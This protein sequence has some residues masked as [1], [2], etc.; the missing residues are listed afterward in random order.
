MTHARPESPATGIGMIRGLSTRASQISITSLAISIWVLFTFAVAQPLLDL[1]GRN[2]EFF[3]ARAAPRMD[4]VLVA[5]L[6]LFAIP[7][8]LA[9]LVIAARAVL[10]MLGVVIHGALSTAIAA[11]L[12]VSLVARTPA[13]SL[14]GWAQIT[15]GL[16]LGAALWIAYVRFASLRTGFRFAAIGPFVFLFVFLVLSPTSLLL[17]SSGSIDRPAGVEVGNPTPVVMVVFDEFP[18][19]SLIDSDGDI[20]GE[21]YPNFARLA[22]DG[23]WFRNAMG[24]EQQTE[25][26]MPAIL[27]GRHPVDRDAIPFTADY[28]LTLFSLL[29]DPYEV[30]AVES[31]TEL[32]PEYACSNRPRIVSPASERWPTTV[33]D[34]GIVTAH[35][36]LP[37][38]LTEGLPSISNTWG[39]FGNATDAA[40][41]DFNI[42]RRFNEYVD[43]DR[44]SQIE[45]FI[46]LLEEPSSQPTLHYAHVLLPHIP[47]TYLE[48]GQS[49]LTGGR[50]PGSTPGGWGPDEWL[51]MQAYQ[52]HLIQVQYTDRVLGRVIETLEQSGTYDDSLIVVV[53][54]HG[55]ADIPNVGHRRVITPETVGHVAAVP[56]F[57]KLPGQETTGIDDYRA[58]TI[59]LV[60]TIADV[61]DVEVPWEV[62]GTSLVSSSRPERSST[63]M[64][65]PDGDV[66]FDTSG[67]EKL[68]VASWKEDWFASSDPYSLAPPGFG[69][70]LGMSLDDI[71]TVSDDSLTVRLDHPEWYTGVD[72]DAE[73]FPA[74]L[75]GT[76]SNSSGPIDEAILAVSLNGR[77]EAVVRTYD[78]DGTTR[79]QAMLPP[80]AFRPGDNEVRVLL[81]GEPGTEQPLVRPAGELP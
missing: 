30:R 20:L 32:C 76:I 26:A 67:V 28:P 71:S 42:I 44:R 16:I 15:A 56:L 51:V 80:A 23:V 62:A 25:H 79:F 2:P 37:S 63:T 19:A 69:G 43:A 59:D 68:E 66:T 3:L 64:R 52:R 53:G 11:A 38:D 41:E 57:V 12:V 39:D 5:L 9:L 10:P 13:N 45:R 70:L 1:V 29:S 65:G 72:L 50:A 74:Q 18:V 21:A 40:R 31:V 47:W 61:L 24:V 77:I 58:E 54:D 6:L 8:V 22:R 81:A 46:D 36:V 7:G 75:T 17:W 49:Y 34:L 14:P 55:T 60:P 78:E 4:I 33:S 27:T 35:T 48:T 73:P